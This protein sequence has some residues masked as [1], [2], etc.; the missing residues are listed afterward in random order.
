MTTRPIKKMDFHHFA[1]VKDFREAWR[2]DLEGPIRIDDKLPI[3]LDWRN[4]QS[5]S[6]IIC[7]SAASQKIRELP[8][9]TGRS[10]VEDLNANVL[11]VSD[12]SLSM[13]RTLNLG[14][15]AGSKKQPD[16]IPTLA[17]IFK[18]IVRN[19]TP[20]FFGASAGGWAALT[21]AAE[22]R[23]AIAVPINPQID[24]S[25]YIYFPYYTRKAWASE[26]ESTELPFEGNVANR[27]TSDSA[28][29]VVYIQNKGDAH[30]YEDHFQPFQQRFGNP[31]HLIA[32]TPNLGQG[33]IAPDKKSLQ[34]VLKLVTTSTDVD[35]LST[36]LNKVQLRSSGVDKE[37]KAEDL[38][39]RE[40]SL[41]QR[42]PVLSTQSIPLLPSTETLTIEVDAPHQL[43][44]KTLLFE[45]VFSGV[46]LSRSS[47]KALGLSWSPAFHAPFQYSPAVSA[48]EWTGGTEISIPAGAKT[49]TVTTRE[50]NRSAQHD[51]AKVSTRL[52]FHTTPIVYDET[53][54]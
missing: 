38:R 24:I 45:V 28:S 29:T 31:K 52:S 27:Y 40:K 8:F 48:N 49:V 17:E 35:A 47:A 39:A 23:N 50:W 25:R 34:T 12:P 6:T 19:T 9:W 7:F 22:F 13:D 5:V 16:L 53:T 18:T 37:A 14:W 41:D 44:P 15:Y 2:P 43:E 33:H 54:S 20:I 36:S 11:L 30:H 1:S 46:E 51:L 4:N 21:Y 10:L 3:L 42:Y 26:P 32:L